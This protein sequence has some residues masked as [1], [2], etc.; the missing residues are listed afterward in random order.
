MAQYLPVVYQAA[1]LFLFCFELIQIKARGWS[2][3][4]YQMHL[5]TPFAVVEGTCFSLGNRLRCQITLLSLRYRFTTHRR[6]LCL[7]I[8]ALVHDLASNNYGNMNEYHELI[9][10]RK[11]HFR[12]GDY[13]VQCFKQPLE[14]PCNWIACRLNLWAPFMLNQELASSL[15]HNWQVPLHIH[16]M[17]VEVVV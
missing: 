7:K 11:C 3:G 15:P 6:R 5:N 8:D 1:V 17:P 4:G 2:Y 14:A 13:L 10:V 16:P 9:D 12:C